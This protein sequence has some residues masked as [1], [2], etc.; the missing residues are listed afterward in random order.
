MKINL[1]ESG[2]L[3]NELKARSFDTP[4]TIHI[5][6]DTYTGPCELMFDEHG[7]HV[8]FPAPKKGGKE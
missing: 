7:G 1:K 5:G 4:L 3:S 8:V 2:V 6:K